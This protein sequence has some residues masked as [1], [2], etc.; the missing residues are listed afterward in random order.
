MC[1]SRTAAKK[2]IFF[3]KLG[4]AKTFI[5]YSFV[6]SSFFPQ[7]INEEENLAPAL[8]LPDAHSNDERVLVWATVDATRAILGK[9][10]IDFFRHLHHRCSSTNSREMSLGSWLSFFFFLLFFWKQ[11]CR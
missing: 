11:T 8:R 2:H 5:G 3:Y 4:N 6:F 10:A 1:E 9:E 7:A